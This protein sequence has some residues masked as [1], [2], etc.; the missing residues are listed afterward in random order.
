MYDKFDAIV[1]RDGTKVL[2]GSYS[3]RFTI[4]N[5]LTGKQNIHNQPETEVVFKSQPPSAQSFHAP[6]PIY[7]TTSLSCF[8]YLQEANGKNQRYP[9]LILF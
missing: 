9:V 2:T 4:Y 6:H 8:Q 3:N 7:M 1:N 5:T